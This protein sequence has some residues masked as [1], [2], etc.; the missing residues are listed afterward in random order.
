MPSILCIDDNISGL[1]VRRHLFERHG[2]D[3][4]TARSGAE[5]I[6]RF[7]KEKI[8]LVVV[9]YV[10]P[11]MNGGEVIRQL[12]KINPRLQVILLSSYA[13]TLDLERRVPEADVV[14]RKGRTREVKELLEATDRLLR[15]RNRKPVRKRVKPA[16]KPVTRA[17]LAERPKPGKIVA[18][19]IAAKRRTA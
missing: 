11:E 18:K 14:L 5:G 6:E 7:R 16:R 13:D 10:M 15:R 4:F 3:V 9:D 8:D 19:K 17:T 12:R 1:T 2:H